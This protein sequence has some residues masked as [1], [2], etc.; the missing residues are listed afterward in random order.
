MILYPS[1]FSRFICTVFGNKILPPE[2]DFQ[3]KKC[4]FIVIRLTILEYIVKDNNICQILV[5]IFHLVFV[6]C[7]SHVGVLSLT[8][9]MF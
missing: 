7:F 1:V 9:Q 3:S 8:S 6:E 2:Y 4:I 5:P